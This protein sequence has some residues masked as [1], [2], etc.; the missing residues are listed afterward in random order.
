MTSPW[1]YFMC[2]NVQ[3]VLGISSVVALA[4]VSQRHSDAMDGVTVKTAVMKLIAVS[5]SHFFMKCCNIY[6]YRTKIRRSLVW[7]LNIPFQE[8]ALELVEL[9]LKL[10]MK[11]CKFR[12]TCTSKLGLMCK[13]QKARPTSLVTVFH[14]VDFL[15]WNRQGMF[16]SAAALLSIACQFST[17]WNRLC[18]N[19]RVRFV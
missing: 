18:W 19:S 7:V 17:P 13:M 1:L 8:L 3:H 5:F 15:D 12:F 16:H 4:H 6:R 9:R 2:D 11:N 14:S 10:F